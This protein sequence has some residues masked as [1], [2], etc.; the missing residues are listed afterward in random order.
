MAE[1]VASGWVGNTFHRMDGVHTKVG[2]YG[3]RGL[4]GLGWSGEE[5]LC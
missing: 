4:G 3:L 1:A 5:G 2:G